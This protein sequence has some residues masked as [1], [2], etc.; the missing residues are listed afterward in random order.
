MIHR[1]QWRQGFAHETTCALRD[2]AFET[3]GKHRIVS[4]IAPASIASQRVALSYGAKPERFV[5]WRD[6]DCLVF[7]LS[8]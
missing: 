2:Y 6:Q 3:L 1:S 5:R 8:K 4:L 7:G